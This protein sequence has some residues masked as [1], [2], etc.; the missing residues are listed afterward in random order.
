M[1]RPPAFYLAFLVILPS[2]FILLGLLQIGGSWVSL[3]LWYWGAAFMFGLLCMAGVFLMVSA[4]PH[5]PFNARMLR[6]AAGWGLPFTWFALSGDGLRG[7]VTLD[8]LSS[9]LL[10]RLPVVLAIALG[11]GA[12][13]ANMQ[14]RK[15]N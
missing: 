4:K 14:G 15:A 2:V 8:N 11:F 7:E 13:M 5:L 6:L 10:L 3:P 12:V 1:K 9:A